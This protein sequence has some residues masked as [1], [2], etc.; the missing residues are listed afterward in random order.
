MKYIFGPIGEEWFGG[1][2]MRRVALS[3]FLLKRDKVSG[4]FALLKI[5]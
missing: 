1:F 5:G 4:Y 3:S 2:P